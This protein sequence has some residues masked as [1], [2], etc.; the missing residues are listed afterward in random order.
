MTASLFGAFADSF[1]AGTP[2]LVAGNTAFA[3]DLYQREKGQAGNLF[4]S[5]YSISTALAMTAAGARGQTEKEMATA[6]HFT[7]PPPELARGF[8]QLAERFAQIEK[9]KRVS[10]TVANSLWCEKK[11]PFNAAFLEL[12]RKYYGAEVRPLGFAGDPAAARE[13][14][15]SWIAQKTQDKIRDLLQPSQISPLTTLVL[16][17]AIY[18]KGSWV[19]RFDSKATRPEPFF[20]ARD[21]RVDVPMMSAQFKVR[22]YETGDAVLFALPYSGDDL[23][24]AIILPNAVDGLGALEKELNAASL[25]QW[26]ASLD[27]AR[28]AKASVALPEFKLNCR[29]SLADDL[30]AMGMPSAFGSSADFSGMS[31]ARDLFISEVVHQAFVDVNEEGTEAA[32]ATAVT[33][34]KSIA[35]ERPL[36]L[37][38]DHPFIFLIRERQTGT[39]LFLGRLVNPTPT[40]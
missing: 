8:A 9:Q 17:N 18:F 10:L 5:P 13:T 23:S 24:L 33:M 27:A 1:A 15:N 19:T 11:Y 34:T 26:L 31:S 6:L 37:R 7:L 40:P 25:P 22:S 2:A 3:L 12:N 20:L 39:I 21:K 35:L 29:L 38:A 16:C 36:V 14:I 4:F 32:A 28:E 30:K